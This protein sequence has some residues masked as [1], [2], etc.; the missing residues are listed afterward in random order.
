[1][2][3]NEKGGRKSAGRQNPTQEP[4]RI[5]S[6]PGDDLNPAC[7]ADGQPCLQDYFDAWD[8]LG[9][10]DLPDDER[11]A[12]A[13]LFDTEY[14]TALFNAFCD[15][16][17]ARQELAAEQT[18]TVKAKPETPAP[19]PSVAPEPETAHLDSSIPG[20]YHARS[21][22]LPRLHVYDLEGTS[23]C[24]ALSCED[25]TSVMPDTLPTFVTGGFAANGS[26][27]ELFPSADLRELLLIVCE[28]SA[29]C[30]FEGSDHTVRLEADKDSIATVWI[31]SNMR[32]PAWTPGIRLTDIGAG[33]ISGFVAMTDRQGVEAYTSQA[34]RLTLKP[35]VRG[36]EPAARFWKSV[37]RSGLGE[38]WPRA[39]PIPRGPRAIARIST[40]NLVDWAAPKSNPHYQTIVER[41]FH[42]GALRDWQSDEDKLMHGRTQR[43][44][45]IEH[46]LVMASPGQLNERQL[47]M[48][49]GTEQ[50][51]PLSGVTS[52]LLTPDHD[53]RHHNPTIGD[54]SPESI[55]HLELSP[56]SGTGNQPTVLF[57]STAA[58]SF[59]APYGPAL[60]LSLCVRQSQRADAARKRDSLRQATK[61]ARKKRS[62]DR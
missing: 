39:Y 27:V 22:G 5:P 18:G 47:I 13:A 52:V 1:M 28:G 62:Q 42:V 26:D 10:P 56:G 38:N 25:P 6:G 36:T 37:R 33:G 3:I 44:S 54:L 46:Y 30:H 43:G 40:D 51:I 16:A 15:Y 24:S 53:T 50:F 9:D 31:S 8:R 58:H 55:V 14:G 20:R 17:A 41:A 7:D 59:F 11:L 12:T 45:D 34:D 57:D 4:G 48:H 2:S 35:S 29:V 19:R 21:F 49:R 32:A 61:L 60:G 23:V